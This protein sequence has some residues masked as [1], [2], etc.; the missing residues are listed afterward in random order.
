MSTSPQPEIAE[1]LKLL[2]Q[3]FLPQMKERLAVLEEANRALEAGSLTEEH[4]TAAGAAAH[5]LAGV[6]GTFGLA[7]GTTVA[8]EAEQIY[9]SDSSLDLAT[10]TQI[11]LITKQ[12]ANFIQRHQN[13]AP[14]S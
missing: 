7:E 4:R 2:W 3:K 5:K 8:R 13:V 14:V 9:T 1:A 10:S 6:L 11:G 12:L